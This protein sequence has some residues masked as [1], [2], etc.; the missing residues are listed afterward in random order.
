MKEKIKKAK[1]KVTTFWNDHNEAISVYV[2][3]MIGA[4]IGGIIVANVSEKEGYKQGYEDGKDIYYAVGK[5][6]GSN[7]ILDSIYKDAELSGGEFSQI[8]T[9]YEAE[10]R[11]NV[12]SKILPFEKEQ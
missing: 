1:E 8:M 12:T 2:G 5:N 9:N 4:F 7:A 11:M 6:D 10:K 3:A